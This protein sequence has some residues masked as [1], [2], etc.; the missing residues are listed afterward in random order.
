MEVDIVLGTGPNF[1]VQYDFLDGEGNDGIVPKMLRFWNNPDNG[2][3]QPSTGF[4][5]ASNDNENFDVI[6]TFSNL[7]A[8]VNNYIKLECTKK[9]RYI[10]CTITEPNN[11]YHAPQAYRM[12]FNV[13]GI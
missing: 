10:R 9:Y 4:I 7:P 11:S 6:C 1:W 13:F 3:G 2:Y 12:G 5:S 8:G